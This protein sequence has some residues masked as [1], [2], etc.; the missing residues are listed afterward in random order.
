[1]LLQYR[2]ISGK[3]IASKPPDIEALPSRGS[4]RTSSDES[5]TTQGSL[6]PS[7]AYTAT[8]VDDTI[9]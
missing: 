7:P 1:M 9:F 5:L 6:A 8:I 4:S 3:G 2:S